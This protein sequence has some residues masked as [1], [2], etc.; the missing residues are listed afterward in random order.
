MKK[1]TKNKFNLP[2]VIISFLAIAIIIVT[3]AIFNTFKSSTLDILVAPASATV[4]IDNKI[5]KNG[6]HKFYPGTY[7]VKIE[8]ENFTTKELDITLNNNEISTL[9][10]YLLESDGSYSWYLSHKDDSMLLTKIGDKT[11]ENLAKSYLETYNIT[12]DL[13]IIYANYDS[14]WNYTE[15]RIDGGNFSECKTDFCLKISD[16][17]GGN[18]NAALSILKDKGYDPSTYEILYINTPI[19]PLE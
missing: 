10:T 8:K 12:K 9:Y 11:S 17:T 6:T 16:T 7:H 3:I 4:T 14:S 18:Y 1:K 2:I 19:K 15:F 5:Y 13:P